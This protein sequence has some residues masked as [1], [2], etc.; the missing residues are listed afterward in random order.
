MSATVPDLSRLF[1]FVP[2][3][4]QQDIAAIEGELPEFLR[5]TM[6]VNG[7]ARFRRGELAYRNWLDGD[8]LVVALRFAADGVAC[9]ARFVGGHKW[10]QEEAAG[11]ALFRAFGTGFPGDRL[12]ATGL[13]S[14]V[15]VSVYPFAGM[16]LAFGEQGLP[17]R[18]DPNTLQT[19]GEHNFGRLAPFSPFSAHPKIDPG[20]GELFNFGVSFATD[21][22]MLQIYRFAADG[23]LMLRRRLPLERPIS[24]HDFALSERHAAFYLAPYL[25]DVGAVLER[26]ATVLEA[27][28]WKPELGTRLLILERSS[29][30]PVC[31]LPIGNRYCLHH[32]N[33][34]EEDGRLILDLVELE[35]P[36]YPDYQDIPDLFARVRPAHPVR[37]VVDLERHAVVERREVP[38]TL[39][40]DFPSVDAHRTARRYRDAW[41]L[42]I[43]ATGRAGS[44]FFDTLVRLDWESGAVAESYASPSPVLLGGEP[45]FVP[46]T[47]GAR[48]GV[49]LCQEFDAVTR[50]SSFALFDALALGRGP[51]ARVRL[52]GPLPPGFHSYFS[53]G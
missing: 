29:G 24:L 9:T 28:A 23:E 7:P 48:D 19:L 21:R 17:W 38:F 5:G 14:P 35:E 42:A 36:A 10:I 6:Y 49:V 40:A 13:E 1:D 4:G 46:T 43:S 11:R 32:C 50:A 52:A 20:T 33:A 27:L 51:F 15:N 41:M 25:L 53:A 26:G 34:F 37:L 47:A 3:Q 18:L 12:A 31:D 45:V 2:G 22:P 44:K 8:G 30:E 39:A 16:L